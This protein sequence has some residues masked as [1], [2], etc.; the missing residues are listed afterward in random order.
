[1][2]EKLV[3]RLGVS[4]SLCSIQTWSSSFCSPHHKPEVSTCQCHTT[5]LTSACVSVIP[6]SWHQHVSMS[7]HSSGVSMCQCH[8][9]SLSSA[10]VNA[11][12]QACRQHVSMPYHKP[13]VSMC[14]CHTTSLSSACVKV[15][16]QYWRQHLS[17]LYHNP[18]S[19][20]RI[21]APS[22]KLYQ[23]WL[24]HSVGTLYL[25]AA[26]HRRGQRPRK[27][28]GTNMTVKAT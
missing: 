16:S 27:G 17:M 21:P 1:M 3:G 22:S 8:T 13:V 24:R 23:I 18:H 25:R 9:T 4:I 11:I 2:T 7:Y 14:Q 28:L 15:I 6:Q 20:H 26:V 10:C 5:I 12:P 19:D